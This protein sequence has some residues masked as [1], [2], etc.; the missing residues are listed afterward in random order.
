MKSFPFLRK[1]QPDGYPLSPVA[2]ELFSRICLQVRDVVL[3]QQR[4][5]QEQ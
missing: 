5:R 4:K 1:D 3:D 2:D